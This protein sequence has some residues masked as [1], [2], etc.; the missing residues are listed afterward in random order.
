MFE[1]HQDFHQP[2]S[3]V[4]IKSKLNNNQLKPPSK[5]LLQKQPPVWPDAVLFCPHLV[6]YNKENMLNSIM[7]TLKKVA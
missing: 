6:I 2:S 1:S 5:K 3:I 4:K 7:K